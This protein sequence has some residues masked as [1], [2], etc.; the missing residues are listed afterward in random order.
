MS[1]TASLLGERWLDTWNFLVMPADELYQYVIAMKPIDVTDDK[2]IWELTWI[3][4]GTPIV[5]SLNVDKAKSDSDDDQR[6]ITAIHEQL[7]LNDR[8]KRFNRSTD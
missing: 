2:E 8:I 4:L 6:F 7:R 3:V 5:V 1:N